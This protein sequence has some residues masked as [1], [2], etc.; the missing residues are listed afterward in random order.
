[1]FVVAYHEQ[2][3]SPYLHLNG[4]LTKLLMT[5][6]IG[7][8]IFFVLSGFLITTILL[9]AREARNYFKV[10]YIRRGLRI[11]PLYYAVLIIS[12]LSHPG[13]IGFGVQIFFWLNLSNLSTAFAPYAIPYLAHFWSLAIEEQFYFVWPAVVRRVNPRTIAYICGGVI[14]GLFV[15]RNLTPILALQD[16]WPE[17]IYRLTPFRVD[18]LCGGALLALIAKYFPSLLTHRISLRIAFLSS[19]LVFLVAG[20]GRDHTSTSLT[21]FGYTAL[22]LCG[23]SLVGLALNPNGLVARFFSNAFLRKTG[24]YSYC[25]YLIHTFVLAYFT[26]HHGFLLRTLRA[27]RL[28]NMS[29]NRTELITIILELAAIYGICALSWNFFEGPLLRLKRHFRYNPVPEHYLA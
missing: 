23:T 10:F 2:R 22:V 5:G 11:L 12:L 29:G 7:V 9:D 1:M 18:T 28:P 20:F 4:F 21:R 16:R 15:V 13:H 24:K 17:F 8:D 14:V 26:A 25:F 19:A 3:I 27:M 6:W